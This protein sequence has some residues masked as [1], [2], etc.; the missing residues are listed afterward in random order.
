MCYRRRHKTQD[1]RHKT[2]TKGMAR[3]TVRQDKYQDQDKDTAPL[4]FCFP[5]RNDD[6]HSMKELT[7]FFGSFFVFRK[8]S[9]K[10]PFAGP[11]AGEVTKN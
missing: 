11:R 9:V 8:K 7:T 6:T 1:T 5:Q 4:A 10:C 3:H 2:K